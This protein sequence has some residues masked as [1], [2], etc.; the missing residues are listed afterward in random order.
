MQ[1]DETLRDAGYDSELAVVPGAGHST[2]LYRD[3]AVVEV[4]RQ[5]LAETV[6]T[7]AE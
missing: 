7:A 1:L 4:I 2:I 5:K 3:S 6:L